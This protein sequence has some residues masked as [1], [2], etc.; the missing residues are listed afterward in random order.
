MKLLTTILLTLIF[1]APSFA[2]T[3]GSISGT[4][5]QDTNTTVADATVS[6][7]S[8]ISPYL[9]FTTVT[10]ASGNYRFENVPSGAYNIS[11]SAVTNGRSNFSQKTAVTLAA[12]ENTIINL[13]LEIYGGIREIVTI[14][15]GTQ[16]N[17]DEVSKSVSVIQNE[18]LE[19]RNE[20]SVA[21][22]LRTVPGLRVQQLGGFGR[23]A[24]IKTRGLRNQD[25]AVLID[26]Q[27][28]RDPAAITGDAS[29]FLSDLTVTNISRVEVLRGSGSSLYGT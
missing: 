7:I 12:G 15:A 4:I 21:D 6:L 26:G 18:E 2:Q 8:Q 9:S 22:A 3:G 23:T 20:I 17:I 24:N 11:A 27:R 5:T 25:T 16:Q 10:D 1:A 28:F 19:N 29:P 14:S 13:N